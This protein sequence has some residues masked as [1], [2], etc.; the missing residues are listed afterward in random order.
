MGVIYWPRKKKFTKEFFDYLS[1]KISL[2][3]YGEYAERQ[4][5]T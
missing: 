4:K 1:K 3:V 2:C 5:K